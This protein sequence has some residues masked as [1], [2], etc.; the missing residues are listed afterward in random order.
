MS[1]GTNTLPRVGEISEAMPEQL[2]CDGYAN[3]LQRPGEPRIPR[4]PQGAAPLLSFTQQQVWL[5]EQ[6]AADVP[7]YH[8]LLILERTGPLDRVALERSVNE[9]LR[10]HEIL[11]TTFPSVDGSVVPAVG[12]H[13]WAEL[14]LTE[15][16]TLPERQRAAEL[17]RIA[18]E[19]VREPFD[20]ANGPLMRIRLLGLSKENYVLVVTLHNLIADEWSLNILARELDA[21]YQ[22]YSTGQPS[23]L[24]ELPVQYADCV[25]WHRNWFAGDVLD[26]HVSYWRERLAG[27]PAVLELP[28]DRPR[29]PVQGFR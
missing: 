16:N 22:A 13:R 14:P 28:T 17:L 12:E 7:L 1:E 9:I 25:D 3:G 26:R 6:L 10:R 24:S 5:H 29:P 19:E 15:L 23:P 4:R 27:I 2:A 20:L 18:T 8:E 11:R 21:L